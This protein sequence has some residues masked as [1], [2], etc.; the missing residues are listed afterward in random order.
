LCI[1]PGAIKLA[2][3]SRAGSEMISRGRAT[4]QP[5]SIFLV[6]DGLN[7]LHLIGYLGEMSDVN[8]TKP[9][10]LNPKQERIGSAGRASLYPYYAGFSQTFAEELISSLSLPR[11]SVILDPW[12]GSGTTMTSSVT[13]GHVGIGYD[14][15]PVMVIASKAR[16]LGCLTK[17][18]VK[19]LLSEISIRAKRIAPPSLGRPDPLS[20]WFCDQSCSFVRRI[21]ASLQHLLVNANVH[22]LLSE[23][24]IVNDLSDLASFFYV[25]LF[26]SLRTVLADFFAS[27]PTWVKAPASKRERRRTSL[28][29]ILRTFQNEVFQ[30]AATLRVDANGSKENGSANVCIGSSERLPLRA[31]SIDCVI[32][33]PPY[34]TRIDYA[35]AT[36]IELALLGI[37]YENGLDRLRRAMIGTSTVPVAPAPTLP[38]WGKTCLRFLAAMERHPSKASAGYYLKN[39]LQYFDAIFRSI[40]EISRVTKSGGVCTL[41]VQD[42][43]YKELH[44]DLPQICIEMG[45]AN[46]LKLR[47]RV[48]FEHTNTMAGLNPGARLYRLK[49]RALESVLFLNRA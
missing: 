10:V 36:K 47:K 41:V 21:E 42:S 3:F 6:G 35:I 45:A 43:H 19:P 23:D 46:S 17:E 26:R 8:S 1:P 12:N 25:A 2:Q 22:R 4:P 28:S 18:S 7:R 32:T 15:N 20:L 11:R 31:G 38:E 14:I 27:N 37:D 9:M 13:E 34:C 29:A 40:S 44:N 30:M 49:P 48:N 39:H 16:L 24:S 5:P 33:S